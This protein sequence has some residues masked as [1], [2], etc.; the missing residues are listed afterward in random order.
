MA[1]C[2]PSPALPGSGSTGLSQTQNS[3]PSGS[4]HKPKTTSNHPQRQASERPDFWVFPSIFFP[5][6]LSEGQTSVVK[7]HGVN[8]KSFTKVLRDASI[9]APA[10]NRRRPLHFEKIG[11][12][13]HFPSRL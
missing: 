10:S 12:G 2:F 6:T 13:I 3:Q 9:G 1:G 4:P 7:P 11:L 5:V 8:P